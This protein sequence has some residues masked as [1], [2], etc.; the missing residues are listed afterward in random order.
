MLLISR[1]S[2]LKLVGDHIIATHSENF[3][4]WSFTL[5]KLHDLSLSTQ[6]LLT[7]KIIQFANPTVTYHHQHQ[8]RYELG[9]LTD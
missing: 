8:M 2:A 6:K 4:A 3:P 1:D 5:T 7:L 9:I